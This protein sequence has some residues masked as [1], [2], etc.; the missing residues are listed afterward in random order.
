MKVYGF[1]EYAHITESPHI[2]YE[3]KYSKILI[4]LKHKASVQL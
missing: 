4:Y 2:I 3:Q 1:E